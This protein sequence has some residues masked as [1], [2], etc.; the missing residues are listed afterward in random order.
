[1]KITRLCNNAFCIDR[2]AEN[3]TYE[4]Y[5]YE[6][7]VAVYSIET[8]K[9]IRKWSGHSKTTTSHVNKFCDKIGINPIKWNDLECDF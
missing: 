5:S 3:G 1:M 6:T 7:L 9:V 8:K 2:T 4:I